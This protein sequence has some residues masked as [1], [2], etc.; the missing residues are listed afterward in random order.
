MPADMLVGSD[1]REAQ[2]DAPPRAVSVCVFV[3]SLRVL[4]VPVGLQRSWQLRYRRN[5]VTC[6]MIEGVQHVKRRKPG[7]S[8][9]FPPTVQADAPRE[10]NSADF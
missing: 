3:C 1:A 7:V 8:W 2:G 6:V 4:C 9:D 10:Q 5:E